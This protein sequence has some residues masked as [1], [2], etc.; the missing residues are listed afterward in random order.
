MS[1][2]VCVRERESK[3]CTRRH[4]Y[5]DTSMSGQDH[6]SVTVHGSMSLLD[7]EFNPEVVDAHVAWMDGRVCESAVR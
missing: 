3:Q 1:V 4:S 2:C 7:G 6:V 5:V